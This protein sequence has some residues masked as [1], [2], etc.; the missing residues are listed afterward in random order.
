LFRIG[1]LIT[2]Q[3]EKYF[4]LPTDNTQAHPSSKLLKSREGSS[5][6][7]QPQ[8]KKEKPSL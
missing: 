2:Q 7:L 1:L 3:P 4:Q 5:I 8:P 6:T